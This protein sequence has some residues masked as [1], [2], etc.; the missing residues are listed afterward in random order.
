MKILVLSPKPPWP[1]HDGGAVAIVR[2]IEGLAACG[3]PVTVLAMRTEKHGPGDAGTDA[4][5][6][7]IAGYESVPVN[8]GI[9]PLKALANLLFSNEPYDL[10]RFISRDYYDALRSA[11]KSDGYDLVQCEGLL[12]SYYADTIKS[13]TGA[14]VVLRAHNAEHRIRELMADN[15]R[16][17]FK[18]LYLRTLASRLKKLEADAVRK[19]DAIVPISEPDFWWFKALSPAAPVLLC[20]TGISVSE[21]LPEDTGGNLKIG[22][23]GAL[24]WQPNIEGLKWF[25]AEVWPSVSK[26]RPDAMLHIA[27]RG[28]P[29]SLPGHLKGKNIVFEGEVADAARF[30]SMMTVMIAPL[31]A[32]SGLRIKI[33]EAMSL[34][35]PVV[36]TPVA[37]EGVPAENKHEI[38]ICNDAGKF[39]GTLISLLDDPVMR[40]AT[41]NA[42]RELVKTRFDNSRQTAALFEFYSKLTHDR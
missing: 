20:E 26:A 14:P 36:A 38:F 24:N 32:G 11:L 5:P 19:F 21:S 4:I 12:F 17:I 15:E 6:S 25:M 41:G 27:G 42:A 18:K 2:C 22:F 31:F 1:P 34:G 8:T 29:P 39:S 9:K 40:E 10:R 28:A 35:K 30:T 33:I 3:A 37:A 13:L 23:I 7:Y 16:N